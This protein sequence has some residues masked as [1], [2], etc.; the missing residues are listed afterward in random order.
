[1]ER[2]KKGGTTITKLCNWVPRNG[3][4]P[5]S[6]SAISLALPRLR[7]LVFL[8]FVSADRTLTVQSSSPPLRHPA[9]RNWIP[10]RSFEICLTRS[11]S[12][13]QLRKPTTRPQLPVPCFDFDSHFWN[14]ARSGPHHQISISISTAGQ[15]SCCKQ[16]YIQGLHLLP[17]A[18]AASHLPPQNSTIT[19]RVTDH[20]RICEITPTN[21]H[22][23]EISPRRHLLYVFGSLKPHP[24]KIC[25]IL[26]SQM[27]TRFSLR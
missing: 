21:T 7:F 22:Q 24:L 25:H 18:P 15:M 23:Q 5:I 20:A 3:L 2:K 10:F 9:H 13:S 16:S 8:L 17:A 19:D 14:C 1:V 6:K 27:R 26:G 11:R 12:L 4:T